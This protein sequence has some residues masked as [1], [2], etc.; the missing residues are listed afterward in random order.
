MRI[1]H[2]L[3]L[4]SCTTDM[5]L[6]RVKIKF[7]STDNSRRYSTINQ[8]RIR[9]KRSQTTDQST[10]ALGST[11]FN[12]YKI[13]SASRGKFKVKHQSFLLLRRRTGRGNELIQ[14]DPVCNMSGS[15]YESLHEVLKAELP[16]VGNLDGSQ[17]LFSHLFAMDAYQ[18]QSDISATP[19]GG[20]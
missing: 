16:G 7:H 12:D 19:C 13:H 5:K 8:V 6:F 18:R 3:L 14:V 1:D 17:L 4:R 9:P 15:G 11:E 20:F 2:Y 10:R